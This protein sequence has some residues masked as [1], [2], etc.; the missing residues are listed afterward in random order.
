MTVAE[1]SQRLTASEE[2]HWI[3]LYRLEPFGDERADL[4]SAQVAQILWNANTKKE[5]ARPITDFMPFYRKRVKPDPNVNQ[6][7]R[8]V[9]SKLMQRKGN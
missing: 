1:L 6:S 3:A 7:V 8:S 4:R 2:A 9:F 5:K